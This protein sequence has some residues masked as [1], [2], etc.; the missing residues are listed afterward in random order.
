MMTPENRQRVEMIA[1][2][3]DI[4]A[5]RLGAHT[6]WETIN[7][8][9]LLNAPLILQFERQ[10]RIAC[11]P[12]SKCGLVQMLCSGRVMIKQYRIRR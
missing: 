1:L 5:G 10:Q 11:E 7:N 6:P 9:Q 8:A 4:Q 3:P 12:E 2:D